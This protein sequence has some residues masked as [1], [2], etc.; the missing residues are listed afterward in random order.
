M[1]FPARAMPACAVRLGRERRAFATSNGG[2]V[3]R[4]P[5]KRL[6]FYNCLPFPAPYIG[7]PADPIFYTNSHGT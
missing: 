2:D 5:D 7:I 3:K 1:E 6:L 4:R